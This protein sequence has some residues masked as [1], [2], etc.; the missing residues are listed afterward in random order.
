M[1]Q[2]F[3]LT[4]AHNRRRI[5]LAMARRRSW[6]WS[7]PGIVLVALLA[8]FFNPED[9]TATHGDFEVVERVVDGDTF[10]L[11]S[12]EGASHR[13]GHAET[14]HLTSR[15]NTSGRKPPPLHS[16]WWKGQRVRLEFDPANASTGHKA[17]T[18]QRRTLAYVFLDD[19]TLLNAEIIKQGCWYSIRKVFPSI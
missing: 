14:K 4:L 2:N 5:D 16:A 12:A 17:N 19:G 7:V 13:R 9:Q 8:A 10:L 3:T 6:K 18:R 1:S 11:A 15:H